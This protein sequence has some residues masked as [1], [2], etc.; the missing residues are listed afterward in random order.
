MAQG[1][2]PDGDAATLDVLAALE[3]FRA[4]GRIRKPSSKRWNRCSRASIRFR[5][6]PRRRP[7]ALSLTVDPVRY[8]VGKR[9]RLG[10]ASTFLAERVAPGEA[11]PVYVQAR[12]IS[13]C[14]RI[15]RRRS[16]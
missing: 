10:V 15:A 1:E 3:K 2:D 14:P 8:V 9:K 16:S 11:L 5:P 13:R 7:A 4:C 12:M 6:R